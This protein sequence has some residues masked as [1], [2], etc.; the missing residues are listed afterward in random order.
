MQQIE[1]EVEVRESVGKGPAR[2]IRR[3]GKIPG[4]LYG[5]GKATPLTLNP[6]DLSKI[7]HS[8]SGENALINLKIKGAKGKQDRIA[9]FRDFQ[10]DPITGEVLHADLF[11][12]SMTQALKVKVPVEL[13]GGAPLGVKEG[14]VLQHNMREVEVECLPTAIPD[15]FSIDASSLKIGEAIHIRELTVPAGVKVLEDPDRVLIS[16]AAPISE[17]KLE[18]LLTATAKEVKEPEVIGKAKEDAEGEAGTAEAKPGAE[19]AKPEAKGKEKEPAA[20]GKEEKK[21]AKPKG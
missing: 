14:G 21:E 2:T 13:I 8:A 12:I 4:V 16:V 11:E 15:R 18:E 6:R 20:G 1:L 5:Q 9:I 3:D 10:I 17:A 19:G 7:R